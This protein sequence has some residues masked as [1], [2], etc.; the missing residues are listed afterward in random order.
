MPFE[1]LYEYRKWKSRFVG[2]VDDDGIKFTTLEKAMTKLS[3]AYNPPSPITFC[4][5]IPWKLKEVWFGL[6][7]CLLLHMLSSSL[8][9]ILMLVMSC[10]R[11][12]RKLYPTKEANAAYAVW[13]TSLN[14][15]LNTDTETR[16]SWARTE[17]WPSRFR[18]LVLQQGAAWRADPTTPSCWHW[19]TSL[20]SWFSKLNQQNNSHFFIIKFSADLTCCSSSTPQSRHMSVEE[21][22]RSSCCYPIIY[23]TSCCMTMK[24]WF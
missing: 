19:V 18:C 11:T 22:I 12:L 17:L 1:K 9:L 16:H 20:L 6:P 8:A 7:L 10:L 13:T 15:C 4:V 2:I 24:T 14:G 5:A 23:I 21:E 3:S